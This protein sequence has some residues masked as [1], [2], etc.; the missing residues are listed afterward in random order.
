MITLLIAAHVAGLVWEVFLG[1]EAGH[2]LVEKF[3]INVEANIPTWYSSSALFFSAL[4]LILIGL[5]TKNAK[6][7]Y[8]WHWILLALIFVFLSCDETAQI[9]EWTVPHVFGILKSQFAQFI[10]WVIPYA[11]LVLLFVI[12]YLRFFFHLPYRFKILFFG[13]G[14]LYVGGALGME[15]LTGAFGR[16]V[17]EGRLHF[18][19]GIIEEIFEMGGIVLFIYTLLSYLAS[20]FGDINLRF[21]VKERSGD[22]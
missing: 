5:A 12:A 14:A 15:L 10:G 18:L 9:H 8:A 20:E 16:V 19:F 2:D 7:P 22:T 1:N 13:A 21:D 11:G 4:L 6:R 17:L 3:D